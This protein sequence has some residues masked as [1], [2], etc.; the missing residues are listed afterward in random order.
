MTPLG[1]VPP[2]DILMLI[3]N[4]GVGGAQRVF[5]DHSRMLGE[6]YRVIDV[7]FNDE[8]GVAYPSGHPLLTL[9]VGGGGAVDKLRNLRRRVAALRR[10]KRDSGAHLCISHMPGA[11]YVNLLSKGSERTIAVVHGSKRGDRLVGG[12]SGLVQNWW[13]PALLPAG[14]RPSTTSLTT[15]RSKRRPRSP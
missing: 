9:D 2:A 15:R 4:L 12:L 14:C 1:A 7:A 8:G 13:P 6:R 10:I 11:D 3:P 5:R